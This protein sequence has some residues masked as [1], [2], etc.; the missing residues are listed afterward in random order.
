M[1]PTAASIFRGGL[2]GKTGRRDVLH[3]VGEVPLACD[4]SLH[5]Y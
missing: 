2:L 1:K 5:G 3:R 4:L